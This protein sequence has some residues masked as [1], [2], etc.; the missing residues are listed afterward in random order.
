MKKNILLIIL[1]QASILII[2]MLLVLSS[3]VNLDETVYDKV[4]ME[5]YHPSSGQIGIQIIPAYD[6]L[7]KIAGRNHP[8][9]PGDVIELQAYCTDESLVPTRSNGNDWYDGGHFQR[10]FEHTWTPEMLDFNTIWKFGYDQVGNA[11]TYLYQLNTN[12]PDAEEA[13]PF[14]A[15]LKMIRSLGYYYLIDFFGNVPIVTQYDS[16]HTLV[17]NNPDFNKGRRELFDTIV[18]DITNCIP[19]L[20]ELSDATKYGR[21]NKWSAYALLAKMYIN[22]EVWAGEAMY[23]E[24]IAVCDSIIDSKRYSLE[25]DYFANFLQHN[26]GSKENIFVIPFDENSTEEVMCFYL[27]TEHYSQQGKYKTIMGPWNG[28]CA[29]PAHYNSFDSID[30]RRNGWSAGPQFGADGVTPLLCVRESTGKPLVYTPDFIDLYEP[31]VK[32]D[33]KTATEYNGARFVKYEIAEGLKNWSMGNDFVVFR[34]ADIL[35][36]KAEALMRKNGGVATPEATS[37]VNKVRTRAKVKTYNASTLTMDELL[38]ERG[39]EFYQEAMRRQDLVRFGKF[40][41]GTWMSDW[42]DRSGESYFY[43]VFPIPQ[44]QI[45]ANALL[46]QNPGY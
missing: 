19:Y 5:N 33:Y 23:D 36:L 45:S 46:T 11:N 26:Q 39:K 3:C 16:T 42:Y 10:L 2:S 43:N 7:R 6:G 13:L 44:K 9:N 22:S 31:G 18:N 4:L 24:C 38:A 32:Y 30:V 28:F 15:E 37:L 27:K 20:S 12:F 1:S 14:I 34:Y 25:S 35:L 41:R 29:L 21:F 17:G 40:V 8:D